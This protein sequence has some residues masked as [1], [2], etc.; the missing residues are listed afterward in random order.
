MRTLCIAVHDKMLAA[1]LGR[2]TGQ[3]FFN[4][5]EIN[6]L[7][8]QVNQAGSNNYPAW[9]LFGAQHKNNSGLISRYTQMGYRV[10]L[11]GESVLPANLHFDSYDLQFC[12]AGTDVFS[13]L[14]A[15]K[16]EIFGYLP[17][18]FANKAH[19]AE[20]VKSLGYARFLPAQATYHA[21]SPPILPDS[22]AQAWIV[23]DVHGAACR[24][25]GG[26]P[27]TVWRADALAEALPEILKTLPPGQEIL[28]SEFL[29]TND[30][31][32]GH[33]EHVVHKMHVC[34]DGSRI[35]PYGRHCQKQVNRCKRELLERN[36][37]VLL[38]DYLGKPCYKTGT[39][40]SIFSF[41]E[42]VSALVFLNSGTAAMYS[43]DFMVPEDGLPRFLEANK[44]AATF[45]EQFDP[46][47]PPIIEAYPQFSSV[48]K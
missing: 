36:G 9:Y 20:A 46:A 42:F 5:T 10:F 1:A 3:T 12:S 14:T 26:L 37:V 27:Y 7:R 31:N 38:S 16:K 40:G 8:S 4:P 32:A 28:V 6:L 25:A 22:S 29:H 17:R 23:K 48:K 11:C 30:P 15:E 13:R 43:V 39:F 21:G 34:C 33:A 41:S 45:C 18:Q 2:D 47:L 24:G 44:L 19:Q 35:I